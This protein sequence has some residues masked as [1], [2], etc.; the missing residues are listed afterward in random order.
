[1]E[2]ENNPEMEAEVA[3]IEI[4]DPII[5]N[6]GKQKR[7]RIKKLLKGKGRLWG[8]VEAVVDEV[9]DILGEDLEGKTLV[10]LVLVYGK[11]PKRK[12]LRNMFG[13]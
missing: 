6:L 9:A 12:Q 4:V 2:N 5:I 1:M 8:E 7:K 13:L 10:P 3:E 11:K